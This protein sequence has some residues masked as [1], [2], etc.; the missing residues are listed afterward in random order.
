L[1]YL[2]IVDE[3]SN[4]FKNVLHAKSVSGAVPLKE[5]GVYSVFV[6]L[7]NTKIEVIEHC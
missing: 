2:F 4:F 3:A 1:I 6:D 5:H 7:G